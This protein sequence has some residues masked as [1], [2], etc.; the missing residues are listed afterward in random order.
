MKRHRHREAR[1]RGWPSPGPQSR[2]LPG[3]VLSGCGRVFFLCLGFLGGTTGATV[4]PNPAITSASAASSTT[5]A[6]GNI[7]DNEAESTEYRTNA[8][9]NN[10]FIEFDF[11]SAVTVDG[12]VN[13]TRG[14]TSSVV[15]GSRLI[16]DTDG[17][18]GFSAATDTV[19]V[20][21][22]ANTGWLGQGYVN[23]FTPVT[24]RKVRWEVTANTGSSHSCGAMEMRFLGTASGTAAIN[25][26][27]AIAGSTPLDSEH[28]LANACNG[29]AGRRTASVPSGNTITP[30]IGYKSSGAGT[31]TYVDIDLGQIRHVTAFDWFDNLA[32]ADRVSGFTVTFANDP[33][34]A[35]PLAVQT[36]TGNTGFARTE[37]FAPVAARY[38]RYRV[39]ATAATNVGL[40]EII[41]YEDGGGQLPLG[42]SAGSNP[43]NGWLHGSKASPLAAAL[44]AFDVANTATAS[45]PCQRWSEGGDELSFAGIAPAASPGQSWGGGT[46]DWD[47]GAF[48][49]A[50]REGAAFP[51]V[52]RFLV[53]KSGAY[54]VTARWKSH[55]VSQCA[56]T[57]SVVV[58]GVT[59][60]GGAVQGF[61]GSTSGTTTP[62]GANPSVTAAANGLSLAQGSTVDI[63]TVP[64]SA[65]GNISVEAGV[66][67]TA[68]ASESTA[69]VVIREFCASNGNGLLDEDGEAS[70]W[71]ELY[72][73]TG[74]AVDLAGWALTDKSSK[75]RQWVFPTRILPHGQRLVVFASGKDGAKRP[76]YGPTSELHTNFSLSKSGEFLGLADPSGQF[77]SSFAPA[78]PAQTDDITYGQGANGLTGFMTPTPGA[79]NGA[80]AS[81]PP[82]LL[83]ISP[84]SGLIAGSTAVTI[85]GYSA[86]HVVRY[87]TDGTEPGLTNGS[88]YTGAPF[89]LAASATVRAR[90]YADNVS[91]PLAQATYSLIG[92]AVQYGVTP[93]T[94]NS[95]LPVL[96]IDMPGAPPSD[97]TPVVGRF[98][99]IDRAADGKARLSGPPAL[100]TRGT[101]KLRGQWSSSFA[102]KSYTI[103]F[104]DAADQDQAL[105]VLGLPAESDWVLYAAY[106]TDPDFLRNVLTGELYRRMG[107]WAPRTRFVEVFFN[108]TNGGAVD[109]ADYHGIYVLRE[110]I[111]VDANRV[112]I[113]KMT[114]YDNNGEALSGGYIIAHDKYGNFE[115]THPELL[116]GN[117]DGITHWPYTGGGAFIYKTPPVT[118]ITAA[119]KTYI[120]DYVLQCDAAI[121]A[122]D[123]K[124][125]ATGLPYT[126]YIGRDSFID[127]HMLMAFGKNQD[128]IRISTYFE[129]DRG[130]KLK[131]SSI[132][133]NDLSQYPADA[134]TAGDN[135]YTWN[136]DVPVSSN[137]TDYFSVD[138]HTAEGWF[139]YL[140]QNPGYMQEWVDRYDRWRT[141]G[142]L[143]MTAINAFLDSQAAELVVP[144]NNATASA[145]TP[146]ARNY[147]RWSRSTRGTSTTG[148]N[149]AAVIFGAASTS[150]INR[151]KTWL[152]Q[153]LDFMDSWVLKKPAASRAGGVAPVGSTVTLA[154]ADLSGSAR[155]HYT[156]DGTDPFVEDGTLSPAAVEYSGAISL[157]QSSLLTARLRAPAAA[158]K[159]TIWSAPLSVHYIVDAQ[160]AA[161][162]NLS[163]TELMYHPSDPTE[164]EIE[165]GFTDPEDFEFIE[166]RNTGP[167]RVNLYDA[168]F[169]LGVTFRFSRSLDLALTE[170]APGQT[171]LV[172]G[173]LAA[174]RFRYG[175][176]AAAR[177]AGEFEDG[178]RLDNGGERILLVD[179]AGATILDFTYSDEGT[180]PAA[181]DGS[182]AS[183]HFLGD[184]PSLGSAWCALA[185]DPGTVAVDADSD[186]Q[187]DRLEWVAGTDPAN[188]ASSFRLTGQTLT[189]G[190]HF[191]FSFPAA[192]GHRYRVESSPDL[193]QW[194]TVGADITP[195]AD[196]T[197]PVSVPAAQGTLFYRVRALG[198]P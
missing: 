36:V 140:H 8:A 122:P 109:G 75:P 94:F 31:N 135:A 198:A 13:V 42:F 158:N 179:G 142:V 100:A 188:P 116:T 74:A 196:E 127:H 54:N 104:W 47:A 91:G 41:F 46:C 76:A 173:N 96:V 45:I 16:F 103:E 12:F 144:D 123:F 86:G 168:A 141:T 11:G 117:R 52:S 71:I 193:V 88:T 6:V 128:G 30:S 155:I 99:L 192:A 90:A 26:T 97:K 67:E 167:T 95:A 153:R 160:P 2:F 118:D 32:S 34:F 24:A 9:G 177:V 1:D 195:A 125:P 87:T 15:T 190:G 84:P 159:H 38:A 112:D 81:L 22:A 53:T 184:S 59:V 154:S 51:V 176:A 180:W 151:H 19:V 43:G 83:A 4:L 61:A 185:A 21:T 48:Y 165:A 39:T 69:T 187:S 138:G 115:Q 65:C 143:D 126:D 119:Q 27:A 171:V 14:S 28:A 40:S 148:A 162:A 130:G 131:M 166:L 72:N 174:F 156:L 137:Y 164:A 145:D 133:D 7:F 114:P 124:N 108:T 146:I 70:D 58:N 66:S 93:S 101:I 78:F 182:G 139:H 113:T 105:E 60:A 80:A 64:V 121:A 111:K 17:I 56:A 79:A 57:V 33:S 68:V 37:S 157:A 82:A 191:A 89:T 194:S 25:G 129:K 150:E 73:G 49:H 85:T 62:S 189:A 149:A 134:G 23:R 186:G 107:R 181:A 29:I 147:A 20:F 18:T 175:I 50:W 161:A 136:C 44:E 102:K 98:T 163:V 106:M 63:V 169:T 110:K 77:V 5:N 197:H 120:S 152:Q 92:S 172:A 55:T 3:S 183:L 178:T 10:T 170:L 35:T 132:W